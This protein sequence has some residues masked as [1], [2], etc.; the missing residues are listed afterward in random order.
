M[1]PSSNRV[2]FRRSYPR[3]RLGLYVR[4]ASNIAHRIGQSI[5]KYGTSPAAGL[6]LGVGVEAARRAY[7]SG[8]ARKR[9]KLSAVKRRYNTRGSYRGRVKRIKKRQKVDAFYAHGV[10]VRELDKGVQSNSGYIEQPIYIGH[11]DVYYGNL[12]GTVMMALMRRLFRKVGT[13]FANVNEL[14]GDSTT[15]KAF[16]L[17]GQYTEYPGGPVLSFTF[18][19]LGNASLKDCGLALKAN[20][21][22][23]FN[24]DRVSITTQAYQMMLKRLILTPYVNGVAAPFQYKLRVDQT[25]V[26]AKVYS[27]LNLQNRT[28]ASSAAGADETNM[29]DIANNPLKGK[30]YDTKG[31]GFIIR[32]RDDADGYTPLIGANDSGLITLD[33][34][35]YSGNMRANMASAPP[36]HAFVGTSKAKNVMMSPGAIRS[37]V[38]S[39]IMTMPFNDFM[40]KMMPLLAGAGSS[41]RTK[42][43]YGKSRL[44]V[45]DKMLDTGV[46]EPVISLGYELES[47]VAAYIIEKK[48]AIAT[49]N[50]VSS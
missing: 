9:Q 38:L 30:F 15:N 18:D 49:Q 23:V 10:V 4:G 24:T 50:N 5:A 40:R 6:G 20:L 44:F 34:S 7:G 26:K 14:V 48:P 16:T 2:G 35:Q 29:L 19:I 32:S 46:D 17:E 36:S 8:S 22:T 1:A 25:Y 3:S 41:T 11:S 45:L 21:D 47:Q 37:S 12:Y 28:T 33:W 13:D 39:S 42:L 43:Y 27:R 31:N